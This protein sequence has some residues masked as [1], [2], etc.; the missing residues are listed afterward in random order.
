MSILSKSQTYP[1]NSVFSILSIEKSFETLPKHNGAGFGSP[2]FALNL[3]ISKP[4]KI[5]NYLPH[6]NVNLNSISYVAQ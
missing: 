4:L 6:Y 3:H 1:Y 2:F 5:Y